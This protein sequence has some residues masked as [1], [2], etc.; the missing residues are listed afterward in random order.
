[1]NQLNKKLSASE[2]LLL[3]VSTHNETLG[4]VSGQV[5]LPKLFI[6]TNGQLRVVFSSDH[7]VEYGGY[8]AIYRIAGKISFAVKVL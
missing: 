3:Q 5:I 6:S 4:L 8:E 2:T 1:M 7:S